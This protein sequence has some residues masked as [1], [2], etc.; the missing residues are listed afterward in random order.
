MTTLLCD[1]SGNGRAS[2]TST[3]E[4]DSAKLGELLRRAREGRGLTLEQVS[5]ETKIPRRHL[6]A[7]EHGNLAAVP[8]GFYR[9]A[10]IRAY[11]RVVNLDQNLAVAELD[12][13]LN[14]PCESAPETR[15]E[16]TPSSKRVL[17]VISV[18]VATAVFGRAMG[19][20]EPALDGD[21]QVRS[22][23]GSPQHSVPSVRETPPDAVVGT[24]RFTQLD[25]V[26]PPSASSEPALA[27]AMEPT[28]ARASAASNGDLAVTTEQ[29]ETRASTD[30]V[31]ELV[32]TTQ[33][34]GA[35][36]TVNGIGWGIAPATIRYLPAGDKRIRVSKEG[37]ATEER[38][39]RVAEGNRRMLDIRL[40]SAP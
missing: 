39:V 7:L 15:Q 40:R 23:A 37:Y 5:N 28:R 19:G 34:E 33:P 25:Q 14:S 10:E 36:V 2:N 38:V 18:V 16:P 20:R 11:A 3:H 9:R 24:S 30:S 32:V 35:R 6:E 22:A 31:T 21:A 12:R 27:V 4:N 29:A 13:A 17:I 26:A 1:S 8:D